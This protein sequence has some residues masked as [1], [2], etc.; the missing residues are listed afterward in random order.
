MN[1]HIWKSWKMCVC[2]FNLACLFC[3]SSAVNL[4]N[5]MC[6]DHELLFIFLSPQIYLCLR[7]FPLSSVSET[8]AVR[9]SSTR[10]AFVSFFK[11]SSPSVP[12]GD[13][14]WVFREAD[15][16]PGYPQPLYHYGKGVPPHGIDTAIWWEPN[17]HTYFFSG[18]RY[19]SD[20]RSAEV[21]TP[22]RLNTSYCLAGTGDTTRRRGPQT[23]TSP[24]QLADGAGSLPPLKEPSSA[25]MGVSQEFK[26]SNLPEFYFSSG[27]IQ[28]LRFMRITT[29][30]KSFAF[31][32]G[33]KRT[34]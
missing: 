26:L 24:N 25:M 1:P 32:V 11:A 33:S 30:F 14:F 7:F 16:M 10:C 12:T 27:N 20:T 31:T 5:T 21:L 29:N 23:A 19:D 8:R 2:H 17:G 22:R 13:R 28:Q 9:G 34:A 3:F 18:D 15:V 6:A 4:M